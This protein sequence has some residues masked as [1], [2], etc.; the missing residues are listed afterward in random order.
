LEGQKRVQRI[1]AGRSGGLRK[2]DTKF[3]KNK[4]ADIT[5]LYMENARKGKAASTG[6][7]AGKNERVNTSCGRRRG[8][9]SHAL[10]GLPRAR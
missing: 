3:V 2:R 6:K 9:G 4:G 7:I 10:G 5:V 1:N 8:Q